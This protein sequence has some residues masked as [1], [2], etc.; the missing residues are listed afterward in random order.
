MYCL[1]RFIF[2]LLIKRKKEG[3]FQGVKLLIIALFFNIKKGVK[4]DR[5]VKF[6]PIEMSFIPPQERSIFIQVQSPFNTYI[7]VYI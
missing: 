2:L 5:G 6:V 1:L 4:E 7:Y 3:R